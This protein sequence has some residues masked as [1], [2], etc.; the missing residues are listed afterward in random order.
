VLNNCVMHALCVVVGMCMRVRCV[1][2]ACVLK[3]NVVHA[4]CVT[5]GVCAE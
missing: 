2:S 3:D 1:V 5:G 4:V